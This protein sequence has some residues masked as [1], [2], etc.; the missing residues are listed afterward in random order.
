MN[1]INNDNNNDNVSWQCKSII[2]LM[3]L[4]TMIVFEN[5]AFQVLL[6]SVFWGYVWMH[7]I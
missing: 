5:V 2:I 3:I 1:N 6:S 7:L 4:T